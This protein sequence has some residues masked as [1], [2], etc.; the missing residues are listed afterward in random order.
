MAVGGGDIVGQGLADKAVLVQGEHFG[1]DVKPAVSAQIV[2]AIRRGD[3][4]ASQQANGDHGFSFLVIFKGVEADKIR[5]EDHFS[6][7]GDVGPVGETVHGVGK[8]RPTDPLDSPG[9]VV[10]T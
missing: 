3:R 2:P 1:V 10:P 5:I 7:A 9:L 4:R 6:A 8:N